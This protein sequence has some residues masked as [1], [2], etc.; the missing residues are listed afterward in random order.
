[1]AFLSR[2]VDLGPPLK[3]S[4]WRKIALGTWR[5]AGDPSVYGMV[6]LDVAPALAYIEKARAESGLRITIS[7]FVGKAIAETLRRHPDINCVLR[8]GRLYGRKSADVFFQ[9]ATDPQGK[10]LSGMTIRGA[11]H[12]SM[13]DI[14]RE[15]D[16]RVKAI[17]EKKDK[18]FSRMKSTMG[19]VPGFLAGIVLHLSGVLMYTLNI[20][21][22]L[23]GVPRDSFGSVMITNIGSLGLDMAFAPLVPYSRIPLLLALGTMADRPVV[24]DGQV[25]VRKMLRICATFDHRVID[26]VHAAHMLKSLHKIFA[27]PEAELRSS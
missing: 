2:N 17:R 21:S 12:K 26:G 22:P 24:Q 8:L 20:W 15:M 23:L 11:E 3:I 18:S 4:S 7:H 27:N 10:D 5:T 25:V 1:M 13:T 9:V 6:D 19:L 14:A 16:E